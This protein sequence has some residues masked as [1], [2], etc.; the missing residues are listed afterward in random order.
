MY[1]VAID[2]ISSILF[3]VQ[4]I[5]KLLFGLCVVHLFVVR[6]ANPLPFSFFPP[7]FSSLS[8]TLFWIPYCIQ[9]DAPP[10]LPSC[11]RVLIRINTG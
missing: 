5:C 9:G 6:S 11:S 4:N 8:P 1:I 2:E 3:D 7:L 10:G